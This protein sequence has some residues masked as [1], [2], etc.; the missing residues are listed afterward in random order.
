MER[1]SPYGKSFAQLNALY[2]ERRIVGASH[3]FLTEALADYTAEAAESAALYALAIEQAATFTDEPTH[4]KHIGLAEALISL[5]RLAEAR[6]H[7]IIGQ[8][9]ARSAGDS[10]WVDHAAELSRSLVA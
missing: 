6:E 10:H 8:R 4:T 9:Q 1:V 2:E 7:L 5:G 3:P